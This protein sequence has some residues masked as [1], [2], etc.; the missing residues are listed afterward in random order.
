MCLD[1]KSLAVVRVVSGV[2]SDFCQR[3]HWLV[4]IVECYSLAL[5]GLVFVDSLF[6][7]ASTALRAVVGLSRTNCVV[8][9]VIQCSLVPILMC[10]WGHNIHVH[11]FKDLSP[12]ILSIRMVRTYG[13]YKYTYMYTGIA[14]ICI[15]RWGLACACP[16]SKFK[17]VWT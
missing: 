7:L 13:K 15:T 12:M 14:I 11:D 10:T 17:Y 8:L 1:R 9:Y 5:S 6:S 3:S 4:S 16:Q 2:W